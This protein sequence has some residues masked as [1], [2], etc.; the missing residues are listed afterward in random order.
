MSRSII[1]RILSVEAT[2]KFLKSQS[3]YSENLQDLQHQESFVKF[4]ATLRKIK[5][6]VEK[7]IRLRVFE[8]FFCAINIKKDFIELMK[9]NETCMN[10]LNFTMIIVFNEQRRIDNDILT[11][12]LA[13]M[14][15][16]K[17]NMRAHVPD[18]GCGAGFWVDVGLDYPSSSFIGI[19]RFYSIM[20]DILQI[21]KKGINLN[22]HTMILKFIDSMNEL[23]YLEYFNVEYPLGEWV[24]V[25]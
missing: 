6:F 22:I 11:D 10:D 3:R 25:L 9:E 14:I 16:E 15:K 23:R 7:V 21:E 24:D 2:I 17:L 13:K 18:I 1:N 5:I 12:T 8:T 19:D 20:I 4:Q